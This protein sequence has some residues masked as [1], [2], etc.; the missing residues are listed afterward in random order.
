MPL[1]FFHL[2]FGDRVYRDEEGIVLR[3]RAAAREEALAVIRDLGRECAGDSTS[4][5]WAG[6]FLL[7]A[8]EQGD[9]LRLPIGHPALDLVG[10]ATVGSRDLARDLEDRRGEL[11]HTT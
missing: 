1:Y 3:D 4:R 8:D 2:A 6:W 7:A 9:F 10:S 11:R 5:R